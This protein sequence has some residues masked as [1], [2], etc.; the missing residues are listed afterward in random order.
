M[1]IIKTHKFASKNELLVS[2]FLKTGQKKIDFSSFKGNDCSMIF[3]RDSKK[4]L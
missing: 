4:V 2:V 1:S 3:Y